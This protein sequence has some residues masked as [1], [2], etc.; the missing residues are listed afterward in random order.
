MQQNLQS[1]QDRLFWDNRKRPHANQPAS[2]R[3]DPRMG[4]RLWWKLKPPRK[5][6]RGPTACEPARL[7]QVCPMER[8]A[9]KRFN[10]MLA[11][12]AACC[13]LAASLN[14]QDYLPGQIPGQVIRTEPVAG[15]MIL[16]S[17]ECAN[18]NVKLCFQPCD[19]K[20]CDPCAKLGFQPCPDCAKACSNCKE[21]IV[22]V[23]CSGGCAPGN[24][25]TCDGKAVAAPCQSC[26]TK[27][28]PCQTCVTKP[29]PCQSC[30]PQ[31]A[32]CQACVTKPACAPV[33]IVSC[34]AAVCQP[35]PCA[36]V[37]KP[38]PCQ[39]KAAPCSPCAT[40]A[41]APCKA[42]ETKPAPCG[43]CGCN[44]AVQQTHHSRPILD[45]IER[46]FHGEGHS[47]HAA[48][49]CASCSS[50]SQIQPVPATTPSQPQPQPMPMPRA[51]SYQETTTMPPLPVPVAPPSVPVPASLAP[52]S[53]SNP[54]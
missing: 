28:A 6:A 8:E 31:P 44:S 33:K 15:G 46:F 22:V 54:N 7:V 23:P 10:M 38:C 49:P 20:P 42:C 27:P 36:P 11:A 4:I 5:E 43:S 39:V 34:P 19:A 32:P 37:A 45:A 40:V 30:A 48:S 53:T 13:L 29:A 47:H 1:C 2:P 21:T 35:A 25:S 50:C 9:M 51:I 18:P 24:C 12:S 17:G 26:V 16:A 3:P 14:A 41:A 52:Y